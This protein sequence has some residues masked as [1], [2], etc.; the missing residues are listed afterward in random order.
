M[1]FTLRIKGNAKE[2]LMA[3][4]N[5]NVS[6][7]R[8]HHEGSLRTTLIADTNDA[9]LSQWFV[10]ETSNVNPFPVGTLLFYS[11]DKEQ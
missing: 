8:V 2:S 7:I 1:L 9:I 10:S 5:H 6:V 3:C 11:C 4:E